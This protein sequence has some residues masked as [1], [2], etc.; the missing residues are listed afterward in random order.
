[1]LR[2]DDMLKGI[3]IVVSPTG[4]QSPTNIDGV[5]N[6]HF[7]CTYHL[8][9]TLNDEGPMP[10]GFLFIC[11]SDIVTYTLC[12]GSPESLSRTEPSK[13]SVGSCKLRCLLR[14]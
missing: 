2:H 14:F 7:Q 9:L 4:G 1:M 8:R 12:I 13:A 5:K 6:I 10:I 3:G 11:I